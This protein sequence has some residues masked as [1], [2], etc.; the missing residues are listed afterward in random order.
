MFWTGS[1]LVA[2]LQGIDA[3]NSRASSRKLSKRGRDMTPLRSFH[4]SAE[5]RPGLAIS[6]VQ[7]V[8][9]RRV[10]VVIVSL[11]PDVVDCIEQKMLAR[12]RLFRPQL[13]RHLPRPIDERYRKLG[14]GLTRV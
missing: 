10:H 1:A 13:L 11:L 2:Y 4:C 5:S 3:L 7:W 14:G 6:F 8:K 9:A 12:C